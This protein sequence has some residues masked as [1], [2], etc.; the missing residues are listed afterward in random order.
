MQKSTQ[1]ASTRACNLRFVNN[2]VHTLDIL[3]LTYDGTEQKYAAVPSN[4]QY[5]QGMCARVI[6]RACNNRDEELKLYFTVL[7]Q[8]PSPHTL[9]L[10][11]TQ[12]VL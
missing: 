3:W 6:V 12:S 7:V 8:L 1:T 4:S 10:S 9:G 5:V 2:S 11:R